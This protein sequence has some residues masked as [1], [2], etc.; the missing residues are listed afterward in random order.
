MF[1]A[2][3]CH[4]PQAVSVHKHRDSIECPSVCACSMQTRM[5]I[6]TDASSHLQGWSQAFCLQVTA[7]SW[8]VCL[9]SRGCP[10]PGASRSMWSV[11][12]YGRAGHQGPLVLQDSAGKTISTTTKWTKHRAISNSALVLFW[13]PT[14]DALGKCSSL[15]FIL[16]SIFSILSVLKCPFLLWKNCH[17]IWYHC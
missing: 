4:R 11:T 13:R 7:E 6:H 9:P 1:I 12:W 15:V 8:R 10:L 17:D 5:H 16:R 2:P 3:S 14:W